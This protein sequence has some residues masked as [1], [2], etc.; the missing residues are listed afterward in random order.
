MLDL[1]AIRSMIVA[2]LYAKLQQPV[3][4]ADDEGD[5]PP[6]PYVVYSL[7]SPYIDIFGKDIEQVVGENLERVRT[8]ELVASFTVYSEDIDEAEELCMRILDHFNREDREVLAEQG[9][10]VVRI[11]DV[12]NRSVALVEHYERRYGAD[13]RFRALDWHVGPGEFIEQAEIT[14]GS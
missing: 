4:R 8:V 13:V 2:G 11:S 12:Q 1:R 7:T 9:L 6:Y 10:V 14:E 3:I 5:V